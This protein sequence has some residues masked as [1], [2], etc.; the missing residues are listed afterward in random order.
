MILT[1]HQ[2]EHAP[3]RGLLEKIRAAD[4]FVILDTVQFSKNGFQNRNKVRTGWITVPVKKHSLKTLIKDIEIGETPNHSWRQLYLAKLTEY[5]NEPHFWEHYYHIE[6]IIK[7]NQTSLAELNIQ[8]LDF[9][10][11]TFKIRTRVMRASL[12]DIPQGKDGSEK[13]LNLCKFFG[14]DTYLAGE[15]GKDY[16]RLDEFEKA[17]INVV[18]NDTSKFEKLSAFDHLFK[19]GAD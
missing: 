7:G 12:F 17:G 9:L 14:A 2:P 13:V 8:I 3:W 6:R 15:G 10:L 18:W 1:I 11:A 4:V 16:M 5:Q 19:Y